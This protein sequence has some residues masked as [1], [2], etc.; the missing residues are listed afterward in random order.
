MRDTISHLKLKLVEAEED[1]SCTALNR[2][3]AK[4]R[5][6]MKDG[7]KVD[8]QVP[9]VVERSMQTSVDLSKSYEDL[10]R[11]ENERLQAKLT[12]IQRSLK[13]VV[14]PI[15]EESVL[16]LPTDEEEID[17]SVLLNQLRNCETLLAELKTHLE[18]KT[19][20]AEALRSELD[21]QKASV[22]APALD[23][24]QV[25]V[26]P[27]MMDEMKEELEKADDKVS[28]SV[29]VNTRSWLRVY[30]MLKVMNVLCR[31]VYFCFIEMK[32]ML[33]DVYTCP[34]P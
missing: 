1:T 18:E 31:H 30:D 8:Q 28:S 5:E 25:T 26:S 16:P 13:E 29:F 2:L 19:A 7:Q 11:T 33:G 22:V 23:L 6:L 34:T 21:Q 12:Q 15:P 3:R 24:D 14:T 4:L 17:R 10:L 27:T 9:V 20:Y 32:Q